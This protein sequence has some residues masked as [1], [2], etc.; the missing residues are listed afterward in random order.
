MIVKILLESP[1]NK[2][3]SLFDAIDRVNIVSSRVGFVK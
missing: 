2:P 3:L 1:P